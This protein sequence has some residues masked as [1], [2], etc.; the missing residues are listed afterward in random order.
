MSKLNALLKTSV[1][2]TDK[3]TITIP[4]VGEVLENEEDYYNLIYSLTAMPID[5]M[6]QLDDIGVDF[7]DINEYD[8][9]L[10]LFGVIQ[11]K[12][13]K[14]VFGELDLSLF[15]YKVNEENGSIFLYDQTNDIVIDRAVQARISEVLRELHH[16][17]CD[18]RKPANAEVKRYMIDRARR[19]M[20][21]SQGRQQPSVLEPLIIAMVNAEQY[22]YD[23]A[24]TRTLT[25]YQFNESVRQVVKKVE[26]D[27]VMGGVY[28]G[29]I[30]TEKLPPGFNDWVHQS[31]SK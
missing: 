24:G 4:T 19:K 2:I 8:L 1:P 12:N 10:Q 20:R 3:I 29:T 5:M 25:I 14:L 7:D 22:K 27:H 18:R 15:D 31:A 21:R 26:Y 6:V 13:T 16:L 23:F 9:F 28:A 11:S 30:E 17:S